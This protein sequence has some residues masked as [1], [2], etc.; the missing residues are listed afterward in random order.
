MIRG[1]DVMAADDFALPPLEQ[2][3]TAAEFTGELQAL[4]HVAEQGLA[5]YVNALNHALCQRLAAGQHHRQ[6]QTRA[7]VGQ[8]FHQG[9][10]IEFVRK[11]AKAGDDPGVGRRRGDP[12]PDRL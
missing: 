5:P 11:G 10:G 7:D 4:A 1:G 12:T 2:I 8:A 6:G 3:A 9:P